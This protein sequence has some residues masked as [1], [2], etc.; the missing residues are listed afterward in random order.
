MSIA[1]D[2]AAMEQ[3]QHEQQQQQPGEPRQQKQSAVLIPELA[4]LIQQ[5]LQPHDLAIA[6]R[7]CRNWQEAWTPFLYYTVRYHHH[8]H[9]HS[10][11][12]QNCHQYSLT[13]G[14]NQRPTESTRIVV[15]FLNLEKYGPW[16]KVLEMSNLV[17]AQ[18]QSPC[19]CRL[20]T[21]PAAATTSRTSTAT[22]SSTA[23]LCSCPPIVQDHLLQLQSCN[24]L[25][26]TQLDISKTVMSLERLDELLGAVP[27][28][29]VFKFEVVNKIESSSSTTAGGSHVRSRTHSGGS[30]SLAGTVSRGYMQQHQSNL[31]LKKPKKTNLEGL[32]QEVIRTIARRLSS[33]LERLELVFSVTG[34]VVLS[35][36][37]ELFANCGA[38]LKALSLTRAE[39]C[40]KD[41]TREWNVSYQAE[42]A[43]LLASL[44]GTSVSSPSH[45]VAA[46]TGLASYSTASSS[47]ATM[48]TSSSSSSISSAYSTSASSTTSSAPHT[49]SKAVPVLESL[50]LHS[51]AVEDREFAWLL[52]HA[53][54]L[55]ELCLHDCRKL[56]RQIVHSIL[57]YTPLLET[58]SLT[59]VPLLHVDGL[60]QLFRTTAV[61]SES[62]TAIATAS[63]S[64]PG[65]Q[66]KNVRM[67]YMLQLDDNV[68]KT[69][70]E[71]QGPSLVKLSLQWCPHVTDEGIIP[72][73]QHC[74]RLQD[75]SLCL[76]K[77]T[78]NIFKDLTEVS[79]TGPGTGAQM[80]R[81]WACAQTL[82]RLEI[83]GQ[84]FVNRIRTSSEQLHPQL[85][86]HMSPNPHNIRNGSSRETVQGSV[87]I[88]SSGT[89]SSNIIRDP[90]TI[91]HHQGYPMYHLRWYSQFSDPFRELQA[92]LETLP[93]L[94][95]L[96]IPA[97]GIEHLIRRGFGPTVQLR[98]LALLNQQGRVWSPEEVEEMLRHIPTLRRLYC[99]KN[100][101]LPSSVPEVTWATLPSRG[102]AASTTTVTATAKVASYY[103]K[104]SDVSR[105]RD[106]GPFAVYRRQGAMMKLLQEHH[107]ELVQLSSTSA[108]GM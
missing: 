11:R 1:I 53:P 50:S 81:L 89:N 6:S 86:H 59:S 2:I 84:M 73:F 102:S 20:G 66:L 108:S 12:Q 94:T 71:H 75:L 103:N 45:A 27:M 28:L 92:Q 51:C 14:R 88:S 74:E 72:I 47:P 80:K 97:K 40:Q 98:S 64:H 83:G 62:T 10:S 65:L 32:E 61:A 30:S 87:G 78:L 106:G 13:A 76:S 22:A 95:H 48:S 93:Q 68:M 25:S 7:V 19:S 38:K 4:F 63:P 39:I 58:L 107:V 70:A 104:N 15:P 29:K 17:V 36:L 55:R 101:I 8:H 85:Y 5:H 82:E 91:A 41:Y 43:A 44:S 49:Q 26:L 42:I 54:G 56:D 60:Q 23:A 100:T 57:A 105:E 35:A 96:G 34:T 3:Q 21:P 31:L 69:L 16:I 67:A 37:E 33:H 52:K 18:H 79:E 46:A 90:Y 99:E 77:P 24:S 9:Y